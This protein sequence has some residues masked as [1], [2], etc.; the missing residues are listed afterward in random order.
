MT[1]A[2]ALPFEPRVISD[3][4]FALFQALVER[5]AGIH[6]S[7]AKRSLLVG[8][9]T[10]RLRALG[11]A[12]FGEY[13]EH[14]LAG[15]E[16]GELVQMLD[17]VSTNETHFFREPAHFTFLEQT[18]LPALR[19]EADEGLRPK[20]LR[21]WSAACST[22][23]EPYTLAMVLL[24]GLPV[25]EGW[26]VEIVATDLST[27]V[28][29]LARR[30]L[31]PLQKSAQIPERYLKQFMLRGVG[32]QEGLMKAGPE[33]REAVRFHRFNLTAPRYELGAPFELV[34]CRNVLIYFSP[35]TKV[36]VVRRL[37]DTLTPTGHLF[38]G[39]SETLVNTGLPIQTVV[40]TVHRRREAP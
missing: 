13:Y 34:F 17:C 14:V 5:E 37:L 16:D 38:L 22:G 40:P 39:H 7:Q 28:L 18:L 9:L 11:L 20:R 4:E 10:R 26:T 8:R 33:L 23:E 6:L 12:S 25:S 24:A 35:Q 3:R 15:G 27:R 1:S 2:S 32:R 29:D 19:A 36:Q 21:A 30:A 31:W